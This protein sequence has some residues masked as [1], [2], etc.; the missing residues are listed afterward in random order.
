MEE[1]ETTDGL[2]KKINKM[3]LNKYYSEINQQ[4]CQL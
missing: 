1:Y 4:L 2:L 3:S